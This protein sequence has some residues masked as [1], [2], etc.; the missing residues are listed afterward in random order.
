MHMLMHPVHSTCCWIRP[1]Q[2]YDRGKAT[3]YNSN[4]IFSLREI[5]L[6]VIEMH[7]IENFHFHLVYITVFR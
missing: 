3:L 2:R 1:R 5:G 4:G 6:L 7:C